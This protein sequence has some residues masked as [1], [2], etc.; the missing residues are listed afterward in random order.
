MHA[1]PSVPALQLRVRLPGLPLQPDSGL[2][3]G[4]LSDLC[5]VFGLSVEVAWLSLQLG[6]MV[7]SNTETSAKAVDF[8]RLSA[9]QYAKALYWASSKL[10]NF[11]HTSDLLPTIYPVPIFLSLYEL[12]QHFYFCLEWLLWHVCWA[13]SCTSPHPTPH[14]QHSLNTARGLK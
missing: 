11:Y 6:R 8:V 4:L 9:R 13:L 14:T 3:Q 5:H 7:A 1:P 2:L 10:D 12:K